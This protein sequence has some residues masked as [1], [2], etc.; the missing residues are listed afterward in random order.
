MTRI[1]WNRFVYLLLPNSLRGSSNIALLKALISPISSL[2]EQVIN[3]FERANY[4]GTRYQIQYGSQ[5]CHLEKVLND[6]CDLTLRRIFI[7]DSEFQTEVPLY[8]EAEA[9]PVALYTEAEAL[10]IDLY[11]EAEAGDEGNDFTVNVPSDVWSVPQYEI[12]IKSLLNSNKLASKR[13]L[14]KTI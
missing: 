11:T 7:S 6:A 1:D 4:T 10:Y 9:I 5:V 14:I 13:Y 2:Y 12:L 8:T 3:K